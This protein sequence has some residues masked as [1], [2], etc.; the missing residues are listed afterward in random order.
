MTAPPSS[1]GE[2][3]AQLASRYAALPEVTAVALAG[4]RAAGRSDD[5]SDVDLHVYAR[6]E[7]SLEARA[8][9]AAGSPRAEIGNRRFEPGDEWI[10]A[11]TG[12]HVDVMFRDPAWIEDELDRVLVRCEA[13]LGYSTAF[14]CGVLHSAPL[15]DRQGW[16]ARLQARASAP[17]PEALVRAIVAKNQPL[18]R[19]NLSSYLRQLEKAVARG[20]A[21]SANHR[22]AAYLASAFDLLFAVNRL[23]HPGEKR[24]LAVAEACPRRPPDLARDVE[25]LL[26]AAAAPGPDLLR[27]ADAL[28]AQLDALLRDAGLLG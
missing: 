4:S 22:T 21:V 10:D 1:A 8:A 19:A 14:W 3:A 13:R 12:I 25:A 5:A 17:Y 28:G 7:P 27:R 6:P 11:G 26:A 2:L 15:F 23:P 20:D 9:I 16:Y 18:L 24:L